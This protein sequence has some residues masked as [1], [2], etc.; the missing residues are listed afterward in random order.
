MNPTTLPGQL[1]CLV[2]YFL[3]T[4]YCS[5]VQIYN[6]WLFL[7]RFPHLGHYLRCLYEVQINSKFQKSCGVIH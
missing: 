7:C 1:Q 5:N 3:P 2:S 6:S 4:L